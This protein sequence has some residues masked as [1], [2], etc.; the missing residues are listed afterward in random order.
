MVAF[1]N[2]IQREIMNAEDEA[3]LIKAIA[4][5]LQRLQKHRNY[6][7]DRYIMNMIASLTAL[8]AEDLSTK[9]LD[10]VELATAIFRQFQLGK[11]VRL[12]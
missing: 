10:N 6:N 9:S 3:V 5:S 2:E 8:R 1:C 12:F 7:E 11:S 4:N